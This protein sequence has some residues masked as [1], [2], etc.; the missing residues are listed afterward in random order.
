MDLSVSQFRITATC[1]GLAYAGDFP[2]QRGHARTV[3]A[4]DLHREE[5][6][7]V[8]HTLPDPPWPH[9]DAATTGE[10]CC[11]IPMDY[12]EVFGIRRYQCR[13]RDRHPAIYV[14]LNTGERI[15]DEDLRWLGGEYDAL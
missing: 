14:N 3:L 1:Y 10:K 15:G 13:H 7:E 8:A 4:C 12:Q 11:G 6:R 2:S 5:N 9:P